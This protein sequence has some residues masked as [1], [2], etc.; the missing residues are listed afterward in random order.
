[1]L[2]TVPTSLYYTLIV[3]LG[4]FIFGF[5]ASV[6]SGAI[7]FID[8]EFALT[9]WQQGFVVSS[10]TL[11]ALFSMLFAGAISD[12]IGRRKALII[13]AM[14][15]F[16]SAIC[17][18]LAP[19]YALL[20]LARFIGGIAFCSLIIA[21]VYISEIS[22]AKHRGKMVSVNQLNIVLGFALSYFSNYSVSYTHL[23]LPTS[24]LV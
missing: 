10:P 22:S 19:N 1:M 23:T 13:V 8:V 16:I 12:A 20:V 5:D 24:D 15:Y 7:G 9:D 18:A 2:K 3:S 21:P 17:S 6:I 14:L 4:G 11:G